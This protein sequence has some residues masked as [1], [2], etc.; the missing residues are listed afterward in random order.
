MEG[1]EAVRERG[2]ENSPSYPHPTHLCKEII[3]EV[4]TMPISA[5]VFKRESR[6]QSN[7]CSVTHGVKTESANA[8]PRKNL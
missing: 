3:P 7:Q 6:K 1:E 2:K 5:S 8:F 4:K